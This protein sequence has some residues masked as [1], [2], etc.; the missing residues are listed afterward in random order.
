[1]PKS[2]LSPLAL[3]Y[4]GLIATPLFWAGN[5]VVA[6][7]VV[8]SIPPVSLAFWR[9]VLAL[10]I[11]LPFG[12]PYVRRQWPLIRQHWGSIL[13]LA[14]LSVTTFNTLLYMAAQTTTAI[15]ITLINSTIPV[16]VALLAWLILGERTRP[17]QTAGIAVA[18]AGMLL[19][20]AQGRLTQLSGFT[21]KSGDLVMVAA[22]AIWGVY[23]V[24]L[25]RQ[26]L[27][28]H[29]LTF[30]TV[31]IAAG[32]LILAPFYLADLLFGAGGFTPTLTQAP[33]F[34]YVAIFPGILAYACWNHAVLIVGPSVSAIFMYLVPVFAA[35][36]AWLFLDERLA[37][38]H[39][40]GGLL[41]LAGLYLTTR[42][43]AK[44]A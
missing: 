15:N 30:L 21:F 12:L 26:A 10:L 29:S 22:V 33:V 3:A 40:T 2:I 36:L 1:M 19:V 41:I 13:I 43:A 20:I 24:L 42:P 16:M 28:L 25:R 17:Q 32:T 5:A 44:P 18:M 14:L 39:L 8:H 9:W 35:I 23:S 11:I 34:L 4:I 7:G 6:R 38:Y 31:Q 27:P 37:S